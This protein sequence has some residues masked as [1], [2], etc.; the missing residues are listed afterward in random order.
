MPNF[1]SQLWTRNEYRRQC[2][3]TIGGSLLGAASNRFNDRGVCPGD[4][5]YVWSFVHA[6]LLLIGRM[7]VDAVV[8]FQE[9]CR[10]LG[11]SDFSDDLTDH[12]IARCSTQKRAENEVPL[13]IIRQLAFLSPNG[14]VKV[15]KF[16]SANEP[17]PQTFRGVRQLTA[18]SA[19]LL[20]G[21]L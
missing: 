13:A 19:A 5:L 15:P 20:D 17:D 7:E 14:E 18:A 8:S 10:R 11:T 16:R 21:L 6:R 1:F 4:I 9:A 3:T 2:I 12:A